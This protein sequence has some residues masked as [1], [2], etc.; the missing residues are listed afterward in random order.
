MAPSVR[1]DTF[2]TLE[3][4]WQ[5]LLPVA[6]VDTVFLTPQWQRIWWQKFGQRAELCLLSLRE[7]NQ[8][9]GIAP[10]MREG[11]TL[12]FVGDT[13]VC[14]YLDFIVARGKE[15]AFYETLLDYLDK[16]DRIA[17]DLHCLAASSPALTNLVPLA[18]KRGYSVETTL[19]DVCPRVDLPPSWE[20]Y[21][22]L[23]AKK[24]RHELRRK[25]RR[26][27]ENGEAR[28]YAIERPEELT[29]GLE[30][31]F[32]LHRQSRQDK[33]KFMTDEMAHF[34]R[35]IA[36]MAAEMGHLKLYFLEIEGVRTST[37]LCFD[38][39]DELSLYNSGYDP[40]YASLSVGLL[41]KA[42]CLKE[43]IAAGKKRF[44]FLRGAEP[45]KYD[46]GGQDL[47]IYRC[48]VRKS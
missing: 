3:E 11:N 40:A 15:V 7:D 5:R 22:A 34:F 41:L 25:M 24:D 4:A 38:Y 14:D 42:F 8:L 32:R 18:E 30:E 37:A 21:L 2:S 6:N 9:L 12:S 1:V 44:D 28:Y 46:L 48:L 31:F 47:P 45:Y 19:E 43:A 27:F 33:A 20:E 10:L 13:D 17:L 29:E 39:G 23:L 35:Q 16:D 26:L 36:T